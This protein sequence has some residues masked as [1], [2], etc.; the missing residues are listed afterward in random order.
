MEIGF[1]RVEHIV[2]KGANAD[3]Q[4]F[5]MFLQCFQKSVS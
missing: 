1:D 5:L 3:N 2:G 4:H